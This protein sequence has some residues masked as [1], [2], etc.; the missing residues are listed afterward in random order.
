MRWKQP[1]LDADGQ[2]EEMPEVAES[3]R[4]PMPRFERQR[5][6]PAIWPWTYLIDGNPQDFMA[7]PDPADDF[8]FL[9]RSVGVDGNKLD[10]AGELAVVQVDDVVVGHGQSP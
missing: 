4:I 3:P 6:G 5:L 7:I 10:A 2:L 1:A 9:V 8:E